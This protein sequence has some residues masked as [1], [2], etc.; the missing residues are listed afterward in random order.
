[1]SFLRH[2]SL[3]TIH[4]SLFALLFSLSI[5]AQTTFDGDATP[6]DLY[7]LAPDYMHDFFDAIVAE[8]CDLIKQQEGVGTYFGYT[9]NYKL[10]GWGDYSTTNGIR[11]TG[12][13]RDGTCFFGILIKE[14]TARVGSDDHYVE[15]DRATGAIREIIR[16]DER[17]FY[18]VTMREPYSFGRQDYVGGDYYIGEF[19]DGKRH[20]QGI[21]F[22]SN[23]NYWYGTFSEGYRNGYGAL[24]IPAANRIISG[25]WLGDTK[26]E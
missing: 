12:M 25:K 8:E 16:G 23:G 19:L 4:F 2:Y 5:S 20:G 3:F 6:L 21:Y 22:W 15:Y 26:Q 17:L 7:E 10:F 1:M 9:R 18:P 13:F 14:E 24:F 11:W